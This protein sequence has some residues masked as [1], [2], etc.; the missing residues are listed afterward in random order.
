MYQYFWR[1]IFLLLPVLVG[2]TLVVF[3]LMHLAPGDPALLIAGQ[4]APP[5]VYERIRRSLGL[6]RP[7]YEQYLLFLARVA[8]GDLGRSLLLNERVADLVG[9]ALAVTLGLA[10]AGLGLSYLMGVPVGIVS[11]VR[12][13]SFVDQ[14]SMV[15][16]LVFVSVPPFWLGLILM[17][18]FGLRLGW[19]PVSGHGS[20][21]HDV[22][23][24]VTL[25][26][27]GAALVARMTRSAMLEV[28]RQDFVRTARSKG[29]AER[30][31][32]Y[33]HSLRNAVI[34]IISLLGLRLG[35]TVGG[36]VTLEMVFSRPG[37]GRLLVNSI[38]SRDYPVVQGVLLILAFSVM[39]GNLLADVLYAV[40]DPRIK[41]R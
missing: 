4:N 29:L 6:D 41:F 13:N 16:A 31:V 32:I 15:G 40:A 34:P 22:L 23:P 21:A 17:Y 26:L 36:A 18:V 3:L 2:V 5:E 24:A 9:Q 39:L 20:F 30:V 38:L 1:R 7:L 25:G 10:L 35:W 19:F 12:S 37:M 14:A 28:I 11:A 33:K 8:R 27:G